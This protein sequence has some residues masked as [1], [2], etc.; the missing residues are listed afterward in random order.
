MDITILFIHFHVDGSNG[1]LSI[2]H[3]L[4]SPLLKIRNKQSFYLLVKQNE[5]HLAVLVKKIKQYLHSF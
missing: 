2:K 1:N 4:T 3:Q 5:G